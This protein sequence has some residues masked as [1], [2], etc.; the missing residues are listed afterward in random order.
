MM[1]GGRNPAEKKW[2]YRRR[3]VDDPVPADRQLVG[4]IFTEMGRQPWVV[5][6]QMLTSDGVSPLV[7]PASCS[8]RW[9]C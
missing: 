2:F 3:A 8:P 9:S 6:S 5:Y 1:R 7:G 4:W